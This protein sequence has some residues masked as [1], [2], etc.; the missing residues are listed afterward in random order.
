MVMSYFRGLSLGFHYVRWMMKCFLMKIVEE[1]TVLSWTRC[2]YAGESWVFQH[3]FL[4]QLQGLND[5]ASY[6]EMKKIME[7]SFE[8]LEEF[9]W[10]YLGMSL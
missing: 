2:H 9:H 5:F 8:H 6:V 1:V 4:C 10:D 3:Q 7:N